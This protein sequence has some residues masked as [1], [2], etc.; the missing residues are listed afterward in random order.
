MKLNEIKLPSATEIDR[1]AKE[2]GYKQVDLTNADKDTK[3]KV[4]IKNNDVLCWLLTHF[5]IP[6]ERKPVRDYLHN[7]EIPKYE[8]GIVAK[9]KHIN[10]HQSG[11]QAGMSGK[12]NPKMSSLDIVAAFKYIAK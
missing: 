2:H 4:R 5:K 7:D 10:Y 1:L 11:F 12:D 6:H 3:H 9:D 8:K